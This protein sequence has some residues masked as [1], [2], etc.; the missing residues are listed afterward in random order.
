MDKMQLQTDKDL[1]ELEKR[2]KREYRKAQKEV[3]EKA[4]AFF[5]A[6]QQQDEAMRIRLLKGDITNEEYQNWRRNQ[7]M[8]NQHYTDLEKR[9][10]AEYTQTNVRAASMIND[11]L[12]NTYANNYN[13]QIYLAE[14][15]GKIATSFSLYDR[16]AVRIAVAET[17]GM[18]QTAQVNIPKNLRWN[19]QKVSSALAQGILQGESIRNISKRLQTVTKM[20]NNAA[21]RTAR[22]LTTGAENGGRFQC[23]KRLEAA[24]VEQEKQWMAT[25]DKRTRDSH[26]ALDMETVPMDQTFSNGLMYPGDMSMAHTKPEEVYN[27]R[28]RYVTQFKRFPSTFQRSTDALEESYEDW[29]RGRNKH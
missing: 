23:S 1:E 24:G 2:L 9:L 18:I 15:D 17:P 14:R 26:R 13:Y 5:V 19:E 11:S 16:D 6:F 28:C 8:L 22:T 4:D 25:L 29:K 7:L 21:V 12:Y 10:A 20:N 27:C 3:S